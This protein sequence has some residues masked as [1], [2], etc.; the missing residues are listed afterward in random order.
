MQINRIIT[1]LILPL[2][3]LSACSSK[4]AVTGGGDFASS[5]DMVVSSPSVSADRENLSANVKLSAD[6]S[7]N[8]VSGRGTLRIKRET[9]VQV[10][11]TA[12]GLVEV[13]CV[14]FLPEY[15][16]FIYKLGKEYADVAYSDVSFL[17]NTGIDYPVLESVLLNRVFSPSGM[18]LEQA[19]EKMSFV[20]DGN[21]ITAITPEV[22]GMVYKFSID[23]S[24]GN[25][26][27]TEGIY[28]GTAGVVCTYSDFRNLDG[29][30]FPHSIKLELGGMSLNASL[31]FKLSDIDNDEF[32][33]TPR[34]LNSS[35]EEIG[36]DE[37]LKVLGVF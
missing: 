19:I 35:Y 11:I 13:A 31:E 7:G 32:R 10:G 2:M 1:L 37:L 14:E 4:R 23:K 22:K 25:L 29:S 16:R 21:T 9:G 20:N 6:I 34:N 18:P 15:T 12:L 24:T 8:S 5:V 33:F 28:N 36:F 30:P 17:Q 27:R 3:V 26:V